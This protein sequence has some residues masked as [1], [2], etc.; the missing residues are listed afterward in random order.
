MNGQPFFRCH[1]VVQQ[2]PQGHAQSPEEQAQVV[3]QAV[4]G[5]P[6]A[7]HGGIG[8]PDGDTA[9]DYVK[10]PGL[11]GGEQPRDM[12]LVVQDHEQGHEEFN[13]KGIQLWDAEGW[14]VDGSNRHI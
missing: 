5:V 7:L 3:K 12:V 2:V 14:D 13:L 10:D 9:G 11:G 8:E 6:K 1:V 4:A